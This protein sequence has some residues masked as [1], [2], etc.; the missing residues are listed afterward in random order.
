MSRS[1]V[2]KVALAALIILV[3]GIFLLGVVIMQRI[4]QQVSDTSLESQKLNLRVAALLLQD[5]Y[6]DLKVTIGADG[7]TTKLVMPEIPDL[8]SHSLIDRIGTATGQ[9]A[10]VFSWVPAEKD[11]IRVSTNIIKPDGQ[12][13]VGTMLGNGSAAYAPT[14]SGKTFRGEAVI[15][16]TAYVTQYTPIFN[17]AGDVI[18]ILYVGIKKAEVAEVASAIELRIAIAGIIVALIA[19]V[20]LVVLLRWQL[21][22]LH[23]LGNTIARFV[24]RDFSGDV[25]YTARKDEIGVIA[26]GLVRW[27]ETAGQIKEAEEARI[28]AEKR[29]EDERVQQRNRLAKELEESVGQIVSSVRQATEG[30]MRS[31]RQMR[32][33]ADHS[34]RQSSHVS[35]AANESARSVQ[36]VAAATEEL[37]ASITGIGNQVDESTS[38]ADTAVGEASRA[39]EMV[40][41]LADAAE[42][43]GE[44]VS[45]INDIAAQTNLLA[46]NA[47][48]EAARAGEAGKGFAVVAQEVKN[49][50]NQTAKATDEIAQ[51]IGAIQS[52]TKLTVE[53]IEKVTQT[54]ATINDIT[55]GISASVS[56]QNAAVSEIANSAATAS[57]G[58]SEVVSNIEEIH[59]AASSSGA[60]ASEL[61]TNVGAL[62]GQIE[63]LHRTVSDFLKQ[64]RAG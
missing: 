44:V 45:L 3:S 42:R 31:T 46:L 15:L 22:P 7:E 12:R 60:A 58:S 5:A 49:L 2:F 41:G 1:I 6:P 17:P 38:I 55:N 52:E 51:Q 20:L 57:S 39:N 61:D 59:Q 64:L 30:M 40:S 14:T 53:A 29:N 27:K 8:S 33:S 35:E 63:T 62:S 36:T 24:D 10:T 13:A 28:S 50:A 37:S 11:F 23:V 19:G 48:I 56:E 43:I 4:D 34:V 54:I 47:T 21:G 32:D 9:T 26:D 16:G 18:G 25:A